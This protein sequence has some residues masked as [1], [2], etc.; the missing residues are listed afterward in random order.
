M[1]T[2]VEIGANGANK[3]TTKPFPLALTTLGE[4]LSIGIVV[5][6]SDMTLLFSN[7]Y[8]FKYLNLFPLSDFENKTL[9]E[10]MIFMAE[11]G[12]FGNLEAKDFANITPEGVNDFLSGTTKHNFSGRIMPPN[13]RILE[14][15][16]QNA[17]S[18]YMIISLTDVSVEHEKN[19]VLNIASELGKSGYFTHNYDTNTFEVTSQYLDGLLTESEK[20]TLQN[21]GFWGLAHPDDVEES[22]THWFATVRNNR[23]YDKVTRIKTSRKGIIWLRLHARPHFTDSGRLSRVVCFFEDVTDTL[24]LQDD[25]R[26]AK[27]QAEKTLQSQNNFIARLSHEIRTPMNAVI[28]ITDA[29][30]QHSPNPEIQPKLQLIHSSADSIMNILEGTLNHSKLDADKLMLDSQ[31]GNPR[32]TVENICQIWDL[33]AKKNGT[34][35]RCRIDDKAPAEILF[36]RFRYEQCLNNLISNAVKFTPNGH[37]DVILT[38]VEKEGKQPRLVLAVSDSGIGMTKEQQ[39][40]IFD[41]YT[42]ADQSISSRFGGTGLGMSITK[43]IIEMMGG[44][45]SVR[46]E[47]GKGTIF[48]LT[49]PVEITA[50]EKDDASTAIIDH[51]MDDA[52]TEQSP[53]SNLKILV[54][55]DNPI[56]HMVVESLLQSVVGTMYKANN[57]QEVM[58]ILEVHDIDIILMDI[59]MPVMDGIEATLAIRSANKRWSD[60]LI[61]ALTADPQYQQLRLCKNIGMDE[62]LAKPVKLTTILEAFDRVLDLDRANAPY[63]EVYQAAG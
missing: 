59:H 54:A 16:S 15:Q 17:A 4:C 33:Q 23:P 10:I 12:D 34:T 47:M 20:I 2:T 52:G 43:K 51:I 56:N 60:I 44:S 30:I 5:V 46:S 63:K 50:K 25:L 22:K 48:A 45:I 31:P 26:K 39:G 62:S 21:D 53:Y 32:E 57:G 36:D 41:A 35:I 8:A 55:D 49:L 13:G 1:V 37:V 29:L 7:K 58:E 38:L 40:R 9:P 6:A 19:E 18:D 11:R 27:D 61:I 42:Q 14:V 3:E 24:S 28:G